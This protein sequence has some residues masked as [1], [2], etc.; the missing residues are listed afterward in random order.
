MW[1]PKVNGFLIQFFLI[2]VFTLGFVPKVLAGKLDLMTGYFDLNAKV[3]QQEGQV[4]AI[5]AY[6]ISYAQNVF[7]DHLDLEIGYTLLM[8]ETFGGDL[9]YGIEA[10]LNYY[11][12][13][14][15]TSI[16]G[17][18]QN[19]SLE[20]T[21]LWRPFVGTSFNQ[22]QAQSTNS[23]YAGFGVV[24]GTERALNSYFDLKTMVRYTFL[25]GARAATAN[26]LTV[27]VGITMPFSFG[28]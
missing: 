8:S 11:P 3:G 26:E 18:S 17:R 22:R 19:A 21:P 24:V 2:G 4:S 16:E 25:S 27:F 6:K 28:K 9:A 7:S 20:I 13:T 23:G 5:G 1:R 14:P 12:F 10:G 15:S